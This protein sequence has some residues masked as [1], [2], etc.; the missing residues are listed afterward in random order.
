MD[1]ETQAQV[2]NE[3]YSDEGDRKFPY[4]C[5]Q[6]FLTIGVGYNLDANGLPDDIRRE[7]L[8]R[9][10]LEAEKNAKRIFPDFE[11]FTRNRR[12]AILNMLYNLGPAR[13]LGFRKM[14]RAIAVGDWE[15]AARQAKDSKWY[16]QVQPSRSERILRQLREG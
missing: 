1:C 8:R 2:V 9:Q 15:E 10:L 11:G 12:A 13:L 14:I 4:R 16:T 6:G 5:S 3:L 7:L